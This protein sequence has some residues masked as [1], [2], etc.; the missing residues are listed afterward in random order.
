MKVA[1][2]GA[3]ENTS[4]Y[5]NMCINNLLNKGYQVI[6]YGNK[7]GI[8]N[9]TEIQTEKIYADNIH[10]ITLYIAANKQPEWY[11]LILKCKPKRLIFNPGTENPELST[12]A[13]S[14]GIMVIESCTLLMLNVGDF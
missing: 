3:S 2:I 14:A 12:L 8:I 6:A 5:S 7:K 1:V 13:K 4:R 11:E 9:Q 10:T